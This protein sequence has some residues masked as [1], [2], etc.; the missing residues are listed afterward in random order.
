MHECR[1]EEKGIKKAGRSGLIRLCSGI[2]LGYRSLKTF[3]IITTR[4]LKRQ[5]C[6]SFTVYRGS[7]ATTISSGLDIGLIK[8]LNVPLPI[9]LLA[10]RNPCLRSPCR[11]SADIDSLPNNVE[12]GGSNSFL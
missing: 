5:S 7:R 1:K 3:F 8:S 9:W 12:Y 11:S 10:S 2:R 6:R 4:N